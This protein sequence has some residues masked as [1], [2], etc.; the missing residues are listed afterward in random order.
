MREKPPVDSPMAEAVA[1]LE[2]ADA[3]MRRLIR[4]FGPCTMNRRRPHFE[5]LVQTIVGQQLSGKAAD[6]LYGRLKTLCGSRRLNVASF[7]KFTDADL[8]RAGLSW[9]KVRSLRDLVRKIE[10][11]SLNLKKFARSSDDEVAAAL[12]QV[13]GIGPWSAHM[14]LMFVLHRP[15]VFAGSDLGIRNALQRLYGQRRRRPNFDAVSD[16]WR[17]YRSIACWYLWRSLENR[18]G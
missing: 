7:D 18:E 6:M 10:S 4:K 2:R 14:F 16:R 9:A 15:D 8:R 3:V 17:P 5:S 11:G 12:M 13:K 1:H